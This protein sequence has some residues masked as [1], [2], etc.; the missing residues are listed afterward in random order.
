MRSGTPKESYRETPWGLI[1]YLDY[2]YVE[3]ERKNM[4]LL[5]NIARR[6]TLS[7]LLQHG[8]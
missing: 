3:F 2:K 7:G 6:L 1:S 4:I 8:I 5:M